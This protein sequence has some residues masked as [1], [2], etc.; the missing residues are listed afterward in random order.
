MDPVND[1]FLIESTPEGVDLVVTGPWDPNFSDLFASG[2]V[3]GL[4][5][6]YARGF[7][8]RDLRFLTG[9][10]VRGLKLLARTIDDLEPIYELAPH[11]QSLSLVAGQATLDIARLPQLTSLSAA[12]AAVHESIAYATSLTNLYL[13]GYASPDLWPLAS[14]TKLRSL[15][16]KDRPQLHTLD[17]LGVFQH[18]TSLQIVWAQH[19]HDFSS[20]HTEEA[21]RNLTWLDLNSCKGLETLQPLT[22]LHKLEYLNISDCGDLDSLKPITNLTMLRSLYMHSNTHVLDGDLEPLL[23]LPSLNEVRI[24]SRR[25]YRPS[26]ADI[27]STLSKRAKPPTAT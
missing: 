25:T 18:L 22:Q 15:R 6:N 23:E 14:L 20:L 4:S 12:W 16:L 24:Q 17:G 13:G 10:P 9:L 27:K 8:A 3:D 2:Q 26:S 21:A 11:L 5:L 7:S 19:L 1:G